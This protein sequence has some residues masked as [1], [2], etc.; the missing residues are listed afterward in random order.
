MADL[1]FVDVLVIGAVATVGV[2]LVSYWWSGVMV[3]RDWSW[4]VRKARAPRTD[5]PVRAGKAPRRGKS[6]TTP[7]D[8][9]PPTPTK[10]ASKPRSK[11]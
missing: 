3:R 5:R 9:A 11:K 10:A 6:V 1:S 8:D 4:Q 7:P 2:A